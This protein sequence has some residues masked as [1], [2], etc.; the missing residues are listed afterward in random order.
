MAT[1]LIA[2]DEEPVLDVLCDTARTLGHEVL[3]ARD[4]DEAL[5]LAR[6]HGP[7]LVVTDQ[8]MPRRSGTELIGA[9]RATEAL[10]KVPIILMSSS[11]PRGAEAASRFLEKPVTLERFESA[12][13]ELLSGGGANGAA[14]PSDVEVSLASRRLEELLRWVA[15]EIKTPL[16]AAHMAT[17]LVKKR[18][19]ARGEDADSERLG[20]V[21]RQLDRINTL[22]KSV[23][24][25]S[26]LTDGRVELDRRR[27]D[28]EPFLEN[29]ITE[30]RALEPGFEFM[31]DAEPVVLSFD[32][33]RT[34]QILDNL[35]SNAVKYG[36]P[37]KVVKITLSR[38][39]G[40]VS[41]RVIDKGPGIPASELP[42]IF[43]RFHRTGS[44]GAGHGLGLYIA[45][46]L[47]RLHGGSLTARST[48]GEGTT[49]CLSLPT[50]N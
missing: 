21:I 16:G 43:E 1:V 5:V 25:A 29:I 49:F 24:D 41:I 31:L 35:I 30:W 19:D 44:S 8:M 50:T 46:T 7:D 33:E 34:R 39:P 2:D 12:L 28:L 22:V 9:L 14:P 3:R 15:H 38:S 40:L 4:G 13:R 36:A 48:V 18:L 17:Q 23:L 47:A 45:S 26:R 42:K 11:R 37:S 20:L 6:S 32:A 27:A 10:A